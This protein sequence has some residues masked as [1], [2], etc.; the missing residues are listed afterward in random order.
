MFLKNHKTIRH[1]KI[2]LPN[3][4]QDIFIGKNLTALI[5][6]KVVSSSYSSFVVFCDCN[7]ASLYKEFLEE[8][9]MKLKPAEIILVNP[10]EANKSI[11][12][13]NIS[14]EKCIAAKLDR[15]GCLIAIGGG[16]VGDVAGFIASVYMRGIDMIFIPTTLMAQGDTIINKVAISYKLLKN[17]IGSFY[18]PRFTF[19]DI[20]FLK[21]LPQKEISLGLIEIIKHALIA[22][23]KFV[24]NL[25]MMLSSGSYDWRNYDWR[26]YDWGSI[27]YESL[28][29]KSR[30]VAKDPCDKLGIHKGL[31]YGH[32]FANAFEG[33]SNFNFRHGEA[34][35]IGMRISG[36]ISNTLGILKKTD[37]ELQNSLLASAKLPLKFPHP[38][39][40]DQI[41]NLLKR[42]KI[43]AN[44]RI[45][46]VV[47][48]KIGKYE[49]IN[50]VNETV[51]RLTLKKFLF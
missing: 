12:F 8:I 31:S 44:G 4:R 48:K 35:A 7:V 37:L 32:T 6:K 19:C 9:K 18:S 26:N 42:D 39:N 14:L 16:I 23:P 24:K 49:I 46:L 45:N 33:L 29:I 47:L 5:I 38:A 30:F 10:I 21:S 36:E 34:V 20:D 28:K 2:S 27:V 13:L 11:E 17:V 1:L 22:S 43:S 25:S 40:I 15:N 50:D 3:K 41:I 51:V